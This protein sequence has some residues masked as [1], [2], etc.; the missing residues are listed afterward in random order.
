MTLL[1]QETNF[2]HLCSDINEMAEHIECPYMTDITD[3]CKFGWHQPEMSCTDCK[4]EWLKKP[5]VQK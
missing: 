2:E 5:F 3:E 1:K 4:K